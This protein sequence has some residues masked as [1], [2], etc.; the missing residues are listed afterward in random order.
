ML[1]ELFNRFYEN[2]TVVL[3]TANESIT[4]FAAR[5]GASAE[6]RMREVCNEIEF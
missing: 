4:W 5:I 1:R 6:R 2:K 3:V